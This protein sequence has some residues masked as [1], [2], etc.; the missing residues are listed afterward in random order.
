MLKLFEANDEIVAVTP[1]GIYTYVN[2][3]WH[4]RLGKTPYLSAFQ[5]GDGELWIVTNENIQ[6]V[7]GSSII[8]L[9]EQVEGGPVSSL[10]WE[11]KVLHIGTSMGMFT[12]VN[13]A[14]SMVM[15]TKGKRIH[16][17]VL[18]KNGSLWVATDKGLLQR[19]TTEWRN[20]DDIL[21]ATGTREKYFDI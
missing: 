6:H 17:I 11:G 3:Q 8:D 9:P 13:G 4:S 21:M 15:N 2:G 1:L 7:N 10:L 19:R 14:W 16:A 12:L 5:D 20:L 18:D